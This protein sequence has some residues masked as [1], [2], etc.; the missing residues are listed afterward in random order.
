M[1]WPPTHCLSVGH[2]LAS[3]QAYVQLPFAAT[4]VAIMSRTQRDRIRPP[5]NVV[6]QRSW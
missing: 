4:Q 3:S 2:G 6:R 5:L 1:H